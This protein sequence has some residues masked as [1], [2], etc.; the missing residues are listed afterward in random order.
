MVT[1][2]DRII[3]EVRPFVQTINSDAT[4]RSV[5]LTRCD[6]DTILPAVS[7][8]FEIGEDG[9]P[10]FGS[11]RCDVTPLFVEYCDAT[12]RCTFSQDDFRLDIPATA[13]NKN[14]F[15]IAFSYRCVAGEYNVVMPA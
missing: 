11:P 10:V 1:L 15:S 4:D 8:L 5:E 13:C 12:V 14:N 6:N 3:A 7:T 9:L 2:L